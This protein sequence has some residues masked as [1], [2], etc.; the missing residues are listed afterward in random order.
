MPAVA[1]LMDLRKL[2]FMPIAIQMCRTMIEIGV[3]GA[4]DMLAA[5]LSLQTTLQAEQDAAGNA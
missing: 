3:D 2:A 4:D 5:C 1:G